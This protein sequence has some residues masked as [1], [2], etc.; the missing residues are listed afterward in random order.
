MAAAMA[1]AI[2]VLDGR[3]RNSGL[4]AGISGSVGLRGEATDGVLYG[5]RSSVSWTQEQQPS[6]EHRTVSLTASDL[7]QSLSIMG[8]VTV[9]L[10]VSQEA[11]KVTSLCQ[12][13]KKM[14]NPSARQGSL[15]I[16][17]L[18]LIDLEILKNILT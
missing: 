11:S 12:I 13:Q 1:L 16:A 2:A 6:R 14:Q 4:Q 5:P 18:S 17:N 3:A 7:A 9:G 10:R 8:V 15:K